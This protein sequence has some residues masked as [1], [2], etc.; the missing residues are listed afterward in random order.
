MVSAL[1]EELK[2]VAIEDRRSQIEDAVGTS[3]TALAA[4]ED[5]QGRGMGTL[6]VEVE[7]GGRGGR[8]AGC[9]EQREQWK[10]L[11]ATQP[12]REIELS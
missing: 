7:T 5:P 6:L 9:V 10:D 8:G 11:L 4:K 3:W 12:N 1:L 2:T